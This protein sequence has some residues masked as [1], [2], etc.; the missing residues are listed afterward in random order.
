MTRIL[1]TLSIFSVVFVC[2]IVAA[3]L[4]G[5]SASAASYGAIAYSP[6]SGV[7]GY[8]YDYGSRGAAERRAM[9]ECRA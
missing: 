6:N 7:W 4:S 8:S 2:V 5:P 9:R 3:S 1:K